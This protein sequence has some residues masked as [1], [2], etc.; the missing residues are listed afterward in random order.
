MY[1]KYKGKVDFY[2]VYVREAHAVGSR[3]PARHVKIEQA[4][5]FEERR[6]TATQCSG[7]ISLAIPQVIDDMKNSVATAYNALPD[8]LFILNADATIAYRGD[9]GPRGFKVDEMEKALAKLVK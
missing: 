7:A 6:K 5:T 9:R 3:R 2:W 1:A 4:T 8:R